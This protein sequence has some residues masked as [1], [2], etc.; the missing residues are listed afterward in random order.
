MQVMT[1]VAPLSVFLSVRDYSMQLH[2]LYHHHHLDRDF[3]MAAAVAS[4]SA[5]VGG[6]KVSKVSAVLLEENKDS[7]VGVNVSL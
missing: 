2:F 1:R 3:T 4:T 5:S 7:T 6:A